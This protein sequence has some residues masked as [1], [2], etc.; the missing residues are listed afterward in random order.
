MPAALDKNRF[1]IHAHN[2]RKN[3][4]NHVNPVKKNLELD[5]PAP[6]LINFWLSYGLRKQPAGTELQDEVS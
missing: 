2:L 6:F 1:I 3:Q 5:R 4:R